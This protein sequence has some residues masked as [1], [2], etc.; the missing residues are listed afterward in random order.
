MSN[1]LPYSEKKI[2]RREYA[3]RRIIVVLYFFL[4]TCA[5]CLISLLPSYV[6]SEVKY[7]TISK[8]V[9]NLKSTA[10]ILGGGEDANKKLVG[11]KEKLETLKSY[12][13]KS[14]YTLFNNIILGKTNNV[15]VRTISYSGSS[16][17]ARITVSGVA[18]TR[19][20]LTAFAKNLEQ[21]KEFSN[22]NLPVSNFAKDK[23]IEFNIEV[24][25][26]P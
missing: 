8:E 15:S 18:R 26:R 20:S 2:I 19:E 24:T 4:F 10:D 11:I 5:V 13:G 12:D 9:E 21:N 17:D 6:L 16:K 1:L 23:N 22:V 14:A 3:M 7:Q 25:V